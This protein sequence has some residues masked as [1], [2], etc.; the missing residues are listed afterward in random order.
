MGLA[1]SGD[2]VGLAEIIMRSTKSNHPKTSTQFIGTFRKSSN[3]SSYD[4][5]FSVWSIFCGRSFL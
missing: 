5:L 4:F 2:C 1:V 3:M